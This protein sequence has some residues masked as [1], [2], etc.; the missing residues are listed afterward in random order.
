MTAGE[1]LKFKW[2]TKANLLALKQRKDIGMRN[3]SN[4]Y[5]LNI[6]AERLSCELVSNSLR[7]SVE[8]LQKV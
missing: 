3:R 1:F 7:L 5:I 2:G 4:P 8:D 6:K